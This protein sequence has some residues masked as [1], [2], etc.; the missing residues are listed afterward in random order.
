MEYAKTDPKKGR[1]RSRF[2]GKD[3]E[4]LTR[5]EGSACRRN[6]RPSNVTVRGG[7]LMRGERKLCAARRWEWAGDKFL[8]KS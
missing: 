6:T 4:W 7:S 2:G 3:K 1:E 5:S 8:R